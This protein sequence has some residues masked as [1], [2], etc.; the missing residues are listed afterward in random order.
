M[1]AVLL[2]SVALALVAVGWSAV[3]ALRSGEIRIGL[4]TGLFAMMAVGQAL[5]LRAEW[6][7]PL[8]FDS[9]GAAAVA[10]LLACA[11]GMLVLGVTADIGAERDRVEA[12][13]WDSME[14]VRALG[15]LAVEA[16]LNPDEALSGLLEIG[17]KYLGLEVGF[18]SRV[19]GDS[20][21]IVAIRA[22][23]DHP[24]SLGA[25]LPLEDTFCHSVVTSN[26]PTAIPRMRESAWAERPARSIFGFE[27]FLGAAI[28]VGDEVYGTLGFGSSES[29]SDRFTATEK[30]L[31][32]LM[33]R[34]VAG[35][36]APGRNP[37]PARSSSLRRSPPSASRKQ[38]PVRAIGIDANTILRRIEPKLQRMAGSKVQLDLELAPDLEPAR[39]P[40]IPLERIVRSLVANA[41]QA[42]PHGGRLTLT[43][44]N[45]NVSAADAGDLPAVEPDRYVTLSV[46]DTGNGINADALA[47]VF[48]PASTNDAVIG[49]PDEPLA[50]PTI[51]R[52]LQRAGGDLSIDVVLGQRT[53]FTLFLHRAEDRP[54]PAP[55]AVVPGDTLTARDRDRSPPPQ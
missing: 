3:L 41:L 14:A 44:A 50:L 29:R 49:E 24:V 39:A 30:D 42:M 19:Q 53:T 27:A 1:S 11:L 7:N 54:S 31:L 37:L 17:C 28:P 2:T 55:I 18:V 47:R 22:N 40:G 38:R 16:K 4:L 10:G 26:R 9:G 33:A 36:I 45:V 51:Y 46:S 12:L 52:I 23:D 13:H 15:A 5:A 25:V 34:W 43:T 20:S 8:V 6:G 32:E 48:E 21:A 35:A